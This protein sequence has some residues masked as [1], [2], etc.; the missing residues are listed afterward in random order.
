MNRECA[1]L[2][3]RT[4]GS[5][6]RIRTTNVCRF[7]ASPE[8]V[9]WSKTSKTFWLSSLCK[10]YFVHDFKWEFLSLLTFEI[11]VKG[12]A[13]CFGN[14]D[15]LPFRFG[16]RGRN[17]GQLQRPTGVASLPDGHY[18]VADYENR[19]I[20]VFE[21]SGKYVNRIG[22]G[23]LLGKDHETISNSSLLPSV[24]KSVSYNALF[25]DR[26]LF[27]LE[28]SISSSHIS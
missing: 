7:S 28:L 24:A 3:W 25:V 26:T 1:I 23:N 22:K 15:W 17:T 9:K 5:L 20:S 2:R 14:T 8:N 13:K 18:I 16:V 27:L 4:E 11:R 6:L 21:P 19:W 12:F 10:M